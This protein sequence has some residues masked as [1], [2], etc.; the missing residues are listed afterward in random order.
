MKAINAYIFFDGNCR[1]AMEFYKK[2]LGGE[3][4]VMK[5]GDAP[6]SAKAHTPP[7]SDNRVMHAGLR[8]AHAVLMASDMPAG[9]PYRQDENVNLAVD[10]ESK[11]EVDRLFASLGEGG[12]VMMPMGETFWSHRFVGFRD[13]YGVNWMLNYAKPMP[14]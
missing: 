8:T 12:K 3:L 14:M 4:F 6:E 13:K 5:Y 7:G 9:T 2:C 1:E 11:E 10:C